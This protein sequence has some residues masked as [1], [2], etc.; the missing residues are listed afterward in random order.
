MHKTE[1][2]RKCIR[3]FPSFTVFFF[4]KL[5][6]VP[7]NT[8]KVKLD[9]LWRS[10]SPAVLYAGLRNCDQT[11]RTSPSEVTG[12]SKG[13]RFHSLSGH[14]L[15]C[16]IILS[17]KIFFL[18]SNQFFPC[19][20]TW[21]WPLAL[22]LCNSERRLFL[23]HHSLQ[24]ETAISLLPLPSGLTSGLQKKV[25]PGVAHAPTSMISMFLCCTLY[26]LSMSCLLNI[27]FQV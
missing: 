11:L 8:E 14:M 10:L 12:T 23:L 24:Y 7:G 26:S 6:D 1:D 18:I 17:V 22:L 5:K 2:D 21:L 19:C 9:G 4:C 3:V 13:Q 15:L 25:P 27:M 20:N 16:C